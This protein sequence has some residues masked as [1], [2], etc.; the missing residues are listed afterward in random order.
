MK[1]YNF[2]NALIV[3]LAEGLAIRCTIERLDINGQ[4]YERL[5][6]EF[7]Y[8]NPDFQKVSVHYVP[9]SKKQAVSYYCRLKARDSIYRYAC[10]IWTARRRKKRESVSEYTVLSS[11]LVGMA[12]REL[13]LK[14]Y[15]IRET[16]FWRRVLPNEN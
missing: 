5:C 15:Y 3:V 2:D 14:P 4:P 10:E 6:G 12:E 7:T 11:V 9:L 13:D 16:F 1:Y 8:V